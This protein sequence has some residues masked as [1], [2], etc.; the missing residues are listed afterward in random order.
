MKVIEIAEFGIAKLTSVERPDPQPGP[1]QVLVRVRAVSL[2]YRDL[3]TVQGH[4]N[5]RQKLPLIPLS[6]G[7]GEVV[8]VGAGVR[9][10]KPGDRVVAIFAQK[11]LGGEPTPAARGST[12]GGPGD[13]MAAELVALDEDGLVPIPEHLSFE[14]AATLPCAGVTAWNAVVEQGRVR[15]GDT[16]L[17]LGT[18]G[19]SLFALQFAKAAGA[20]V[21]ITS[22]SDEKL[23]KAKT[24][25]ADH[26]INY[27]TQP[28]WDAAV[29]GLTDK[30]GVDQ[31]VEVGGAGTLA[32]SIKAARMGGTITIIGVLG[33]NATE[34]DLRPVL[35]KGLRLHGVFVGPREM[36]EAM[37]RAITTHRIEPAID[38]VFERDDLQA[39]FEHMAAG[40]HFG[41]IVVRM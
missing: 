9:R 18:G 35:M 21:I 37:N 33:G 14:Q 15:P 2:N 29:L 34:L 38:K 31:V 16:V 23:A 20:Q 27:S 5:P 17:A 7:A 40:R 36:F 8:A 11:W 3:M 39:A 32:R 10:F 26:G 25:G 30:A 19:V 1:G 12:L 41:K 22:S 4:Y 13:G 6:D 24:L 28:D